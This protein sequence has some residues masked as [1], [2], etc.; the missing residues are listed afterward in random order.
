MYKVLA[1]VAVL[2]LAALGTSIITALVTNSTTGKQSKQ[3][4][5]LTHIQSVERRELSA[6]RS[7]LRPKLRKK[8]ASASHAATSLTSLIPAAT[9]HS[10][11][12]G[13]RGCEAWT[14]SRSDSQAS[15]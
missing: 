14:V 13:A 3:I 15:R 11:Y 12:H 10:A 6:L 9:T 8:A 7:K 4:A 2:A 5:A 1:V